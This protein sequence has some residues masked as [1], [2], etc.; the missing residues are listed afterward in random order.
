[1]EPAAVVK[2][3]VNDVPSVDASLVASDDRVD[4]RAHPCD[5]RLAVGLRSVCVYEEPVRRL[6]VPHEAVSDDLHLV[7]L[8][9]RD[10][11]I[12]DIPAEL[13]LLRLQRGRLHLV[14]GRYGVEVPLDEARRVVRRAH[15]YSGR[16][17]DGRPTARPQPQM[18]IFPSHLLLQV[19]TL[20]F[21]AII[22]FGVG[23][24]PS[25]FMASECWRRGFYP[26]QF[27]RDAHV[28]ACRFRRTCSIP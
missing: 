28:G 20:S 11:A 9:E 12:R 6:V 24:R 18:L 10:E 4:V 1:M 2:R 23:A 8:A 22:P 5:Q 17:R 7:L 25:P 27:R 14:L 26:R 13:A 21:Y 19:H 16:D 3:L 15:E